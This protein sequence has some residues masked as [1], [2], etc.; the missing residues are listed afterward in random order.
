MT[1]IKN[2]TLK[3]SSYIHE[4]KK[5]IGKVIN[6]YTGNIIKYEEIAYLKDRSELT[7]YLKN[8]TYNLKK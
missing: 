8:T 5:K 6:I 1:K 2:Q 7:N 3:Y 4:T